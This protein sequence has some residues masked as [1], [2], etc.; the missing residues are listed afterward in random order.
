MIGWVF[1]LLEGK[2]IRLKLGDKE[3]LDFFV[4]FWNNL[5]W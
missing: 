5:D 4:G 2:S 3:D 1:R